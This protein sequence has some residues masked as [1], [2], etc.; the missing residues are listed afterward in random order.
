VTKEERRA[1]LSKP[2][3]LKPGHDVATFDCGRPEL[4]D[5][6]KQWGRRA[7]DADTARTFVVCRGT[8]RVVAYFTLAAG[9]VDH[10][11]EETGERAPRS[12]RQNAF[13]P[14]P[15]VILARVAVDTSE[16]KKG[17]GSAL[18]SEAMRR[19]AQASKLIGARALLVH[20][21]DD[22]LGAYYESLGFRRFN[23]GSKSLFIATKTIRDG[24]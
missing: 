18:V 8:R 7:S 3:A 22:Q 17:L 9:A 14:I 2:A 10:T 20:A 21:L 24:L 11:N 16:Q 4:T 5:W 23:P 12:L 19:A 15:V 6:L 1:R 13:D